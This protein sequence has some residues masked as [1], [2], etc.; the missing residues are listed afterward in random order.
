[1]PPRASRH[2]PK[3]A[4]RSSRVS[5][6]EYVII[7]G[8]DAGFAAAST[9]REEGAGGS[10]LVVSRDPDRPYDRTAVSKGFLAGEKQRA[11][12]LLGGENWFTEHN[13]D[14]LVRTSAMKV[15]TEA[16]TVTLSN[17]DVVTYGKLLLATG[18]NV[19]RLRVD[20]GALDGIHYLRTLLPADE[21]RTDVQDPVVC[22]G[23]SY[24]AT[25]VAATLTAMGHKCTVVMQEEVTLERSFGKTA[26]AYFQKT[27]SD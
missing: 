7:G 13:V 15:D 16:H 22:V 23:G 20:G 27:L 9:L 24:I 4:N 21:L 8:G 2:S 17:K 5:E 19:N 11:D 10:V 3:S 14:L 6:Y 1:M 18:A 26:G 25:E 12:V